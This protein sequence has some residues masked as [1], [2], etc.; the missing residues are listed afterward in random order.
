MNQMMLQYLGHFRCNTQTHS[1][2]AE[3]RYDKCKSLLRDRLRLIGILLK[4]NQNSEE[5]KLN[6]KIFEIDIFGRRHKRRRSE[7]LLSIEKEMT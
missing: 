3:V 6:E 2:N 7:I 5:K 4:D 1:S